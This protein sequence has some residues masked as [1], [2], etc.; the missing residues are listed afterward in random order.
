MIVTYGTSS[1]KRILIDGGRKATYRDLKTHLGRLPQDQ[2]V[3]EL[4]IV[5]HVD[6]DHI[7][8]ILE[9]WDDPALAISFKD[10]WF[11]GYHHLNLGEFEV[12]SPVQGE[13]LSAELVKRVQANELSWNGSFGPNYKKS[14][15]LPKDEKPINIQLDGGMVLTLLSPNRE[16]LRDLVPKWE[17]ECRKAGMVLGSGASD[18]PYDGFE[19]FSG[20]DIDVLAE[21]PFEDDPSEPNGSSIAVIARYEGKTA[22]LSGDAHADLLEASIAHLRHG[23]APLDLDVVKIAHHGS[24]KNVSKSLLQALHC[25]HYL[26]STNGSYFKHPD[27]VA[28]S[29][30]I[31]YGGDNTHICFNYKKSTTLIWDVPSWQQD[32][33]YQIHFPDDN[34]NGYL[35]F[36]I[37]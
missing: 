5:T 36:V 18:P 35:R 10:V 13:H 24:R 19:T 27:P 14:A 20:I 16:K 22:L 1:P 8:G 7:E 2:M 31:K 21:E 15:V 33:D 9:L 23:T 17:S 11:N 29:R 32:H 25:K 28:M 6:R 4:L 26:I 12:F 37:T 30:I 34:K 3:F